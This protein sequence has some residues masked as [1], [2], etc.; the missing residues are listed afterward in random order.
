CSYGAGGIEIR[1]TPICPTKNSESARTDYDRI[2]RISDCQIQSRSSISASP[3]A[4]A[5][6]A[7]SVACTGTASTPDFYDGF[8]VFPDRELVLTG[9][10]VDLDSHYSL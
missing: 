10:I 5:V 1:L 7:P 8:G 9:F 6:I 4:F 2:G 3:T